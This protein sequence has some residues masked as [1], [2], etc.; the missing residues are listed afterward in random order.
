MQQ[1]QANQHQIPLQQSL[2]SQRAA[3]GDTMGRAPAVDSHNPNV[4]VSFF[5]FFADSLDENV[6]VSL[7]SFLPSFLTP[8]FSLSLSLS[9]SH[10]HTHTRSFSLS[11]ARSLALAL[12][13]S[14]FRSL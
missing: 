13:L 4:R 1:L 2:M 9:L 12:A 14:L 7:L 3:G 5:L 8:P 6:G 10:T 11:R